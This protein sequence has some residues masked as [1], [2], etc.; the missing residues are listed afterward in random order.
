MESS[1]LRNASFIRRRS[2]MTSG[3]RISVVV[4]QPSQRFSDCKAASLSRH[5][6]IDSLE[7]IPDA[8]NPPPLSLCTPAAPKG[9]GV[10]PYFDPVQF[11]HGDISDHNNVQL[12]LAAEAWQPVEKVVRRAK[13]GLWNA[14]LQIGVEDVAQ[15]PSPVHSRGRLCHIAFRTIGHLHLKL[16]LSMPGSIMRESGLSTHSEFNLDA[17]A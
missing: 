1:C 13:S 9:D 16:S 11:G 4:P 8:D 14:D 3:C 10:F 17:A 6:P 2:A 5:H 15:A 12:L 7:E